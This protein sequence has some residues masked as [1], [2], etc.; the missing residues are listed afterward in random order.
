MPRAENLQLD[1]NGDFSVV[2]QFL[3]LACSFM[4][5]NEKRKLLSTK[6]IVESAT[7]EYPDKINKFL[8]SLLYL[9][10][11]MNKNR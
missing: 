6:L 7:I 3:A 10:L 4:L 1:R 11:Y 5:Q 9:P 8:C 2:E